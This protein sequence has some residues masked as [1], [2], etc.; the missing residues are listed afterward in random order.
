MAA[1]A[2][3]LVFMWQRRA[4]STMMDS[5]I[6]LCQKWRILQNQKVIQLASPV[7]WEAQQVRR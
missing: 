2:I 6:S 1:A 7:I 4:M 5:P 3:W